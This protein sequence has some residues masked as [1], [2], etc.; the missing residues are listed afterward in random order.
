MVSLRTV[1]LS[2]FILFFLLA[3]LILNYFILFSINAFLGR[4][5]DNSVFYT[6]I[7]VLTVSFPISMLLGQKYSHTF[8]R[9][10]YIFS[11]T[12]LGIALFFLPGLAILWLI[13]FWFSIP[14]DLLTLLLTVIILFI[15]AYCLFNAYQFQVKNLKIELNNLNN[16]VKLLQLSDVNIGSVRNT[17]YLK[18]LVKKVEEINPG[19]V[20]I[21]GDLAD[22]S[23]P[24]HK[25]TFHPFKSL[26]MPVLFVNGNHDTYVS[27]DKLQEALKFAG[28]TILNQDFWVYNDLQIIGVGYSMQRNILDRI[29]KQLDYDKKL[30]S[31]LIYHLPLE[32]DSARKQGIDLQLSGHTHQGQFYP[33]N[34]VVKAIFPYW[35]GLYE[36]ENKY[37]YVSPGTGTW[38]PPMRWGSRNEITIIELIPKSG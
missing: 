36:I 10:L 3:Y 30:P 22:G 12:W 15:S 20:L 13:Q 7:G 16:P 11:M 18:R 6:I 21:T 34:L 8:I 25:E 33:M 31:I 28:I 26:P 17:G 9:I 5:I 38:G 2:L 23:Y 19:I 27:R 24:I 35:K 29:L 14:L 4:P 37:L 32:W 1:Q